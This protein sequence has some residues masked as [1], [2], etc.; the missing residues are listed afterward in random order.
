MALTAEQQAA[1]GGY[2]PQDRPLYTGQKPTD[3]RP[4]NVGTYSPSIVG[5]P[6]RSTQPNLDGLMWLLLGFL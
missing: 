3:V 1:L 2:R 4:G 5:T 6:G